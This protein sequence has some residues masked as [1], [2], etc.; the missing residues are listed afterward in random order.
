[1]PE[2]NVDALLT[3]PRTDIG[4]NPTS[5]DAPA[6]KDMRDEPDFDL[7]ETE[8]RKMETA[9]PAAVDWKLF[10]SRTL[11]ILAH[12]SKDL[13]LA[14][15][16]VFGL[17]R[18]EG[19]KGMAVGI[20]ILNGVVT[21]HWEGLFPG[22]NR[23]RAR[24]GSL[25]WLAE[26]LA[27]VIEG[28]PPASSEAKL[29]ALVAHDRLVD[30]DQFL[31]ERMQKYPPAIGPLIRALR[32]FAREARADL[33][34]VAAAEA[35]AAEAAAAP[36]P[37]QETPAAPP[38]DVSQEASSP[39]AQAPQPERPAPSPAPT[40]SPTP[41]AAPVIADLPVNEGADKAFQSLFNAAARMAGTV[42]QEAP[43]DPRT[44]LAARLAAWGPV[45][46]APPDKAGRTLL[47]PPQKTKLT[48]LQALK[49]AAN[50]QGI[51][52]SAE[53]AFMSSPFWLDSQLMVARA[54]QALGPE[55]DAA[56]LVLIGQL[57]AFLKRV[58]SVVQLTFS[59][60]MP[61]ADPE[62]QAWI[63]QEVSA[64]SGGAADGGGSALDKIKAA[65]ASQGQQGQVIAGLKLLSDYAET[66]HG[67]RENFRAKLE[68]GEYCLRFELLQ[69]LVPLLQSLEQIVA[70]QSLKSWDPVLAV[71]LA[72]LSWRC[73]THKNVI[74]IVDEREI[75]LR[76]SRI[77]ETLSELDI[78][79]AARLTSPQTA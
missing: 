54:M 38:S 9:G 12:R 14:S 32:P 31:S 70:A 10:N 27:G 45:G 69:P 15:R 21:Q 4:R 26:K 78:V 79:Q 29:Y 18:E 44:Y 57:W 63:A 35:K 50:A 40:S 49:A 55:Y 7:L 51:L 74:R 11:D 59:D 5:G 52:L 58:P 25:D 22:L 16:L 1:M 20:S 36:Q 33:E 72:G 13:V 64:G 28:A 65:A 2:I 71:A 62:T 41:S 37:V 42:R 8:F 68:I 67:G 60:G 53:G 46:L 76:K 56:R 66:C 48:E 61:F 24:A 3:D 47:P 43:A 77:A 75:Q 23:E 17:H 6:G 34:A 19:Y 73:Y 39:P 30:A